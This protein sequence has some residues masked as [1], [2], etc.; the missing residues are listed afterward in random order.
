MRIPWM[1]A[2]GTLLVVSEAHAGDFTLTAERTIPV[3]SNRD[4][5]NLWIRREYRD[6]RGTRF[7]VQVMRGK[8]FASWGVSPR[9][10]EGSDAPLGFG[11]TYKTV[12][13]PQGLAVVERHPMWGLSV[14]LKTGESVITV[15][16]QDG[17]EEDALRLAAELAKEGM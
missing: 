7:H 6:T 10:G 14:V 5:G 12:E 15:E 1:I 16:T 4:Q 8:V 11:A 2:L 9:D 3:T 17:P 13:I